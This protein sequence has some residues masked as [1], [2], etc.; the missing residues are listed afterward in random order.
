M[1]KYK[2]YNNQYTYVAMLVLT[3]KIPRDKTVG[4][5]LNRYRLGHWWV[6]AMVLNVQSISF[7]KKLI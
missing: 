4:C 2:L 6:P 5:I 7:F 3:V 1:C